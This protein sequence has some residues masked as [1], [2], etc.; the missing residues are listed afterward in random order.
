MARTAKAKNVE[1]AVDNEVA[2]LLS[3]MVIIRGVVAVLFGVFALVWPDITVATLGILVSIWLLVSGATGIVTSIVGRHSDRNWIFQ[4]LVAFVELGIGAYLVQRP[5]LSIAT[6]VALVAIV[7]VV[8]GVMGIVMSLLKPAI[9]GGSRLLG[10]IGGVFGVAAGVIIWQYPV[11]G[12]LAFVWV[13]GL[14]TLIIGA[15]LIVEGIELE[16]ELKA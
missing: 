5:G 11:A 3:R 16:K 13:L 14:Y 6:F 12:S 1:Q 2:G 4:L 9:S 7:L 8:E 10:V 15:F